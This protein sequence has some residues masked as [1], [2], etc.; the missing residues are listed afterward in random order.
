LGAYSINI[1]GLSNKQ[2]HFHY[3]FGNE[4]F[5]EYGS[6]LVSEGNFVVELL[7]DKHETFLE[8]EF[9][10]KG[11]ARLICDRSLEPFDFPIKDTRKIVFKYGDKDEEITDEIMIIHRDTATLEVGQY[12]YEF[13]ALSIPLKKIHPKFKDEADEDEEDL[14]PGKIVYSSETDEDENKNGDDE[15]DPRWNILKKLK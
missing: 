4:F 6:D 8:A 11:A 14:S 13:I 9:E 5:R 2:H 1:V 10:I 7:L 12:I 3:E 15:V